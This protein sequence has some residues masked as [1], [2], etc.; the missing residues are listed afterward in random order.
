[1][2]Q[3]SLFDGLV[4]NPFS[5]SQDCLAPPE[6]DI[7]GREVFQALM[8]AVIVVMFDERANLRFQIAG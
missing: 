5:L 2:L 8:V 3:A 4:F 7:G 6:V 1:M